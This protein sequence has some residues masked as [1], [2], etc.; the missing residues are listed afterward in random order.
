MAGVKPFVGDLVR[1]LLIITAILGG[2]EIVVRLP[3][4]SELQ[5]IPGIGLSA[6]DLVTAIAYLGVLTLLLGFT[7]KVTAVMASAPD[8]FP[9][10][11]LVTHGLILAGVVLA[12]GSLG[13]FARALLGPSYWAYSVMLLLLAV[14]PIFGMGKILYSYISNRIER[15]ER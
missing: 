4:V 3:M 11:A 6:H 1:L 12:Y 14:I 9:W 5:R 7:M 15:W 10:P 8:A 2:R 13:P